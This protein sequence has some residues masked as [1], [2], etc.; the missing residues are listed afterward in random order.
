LARRWP[1]WL[2]ATIFFYGGIL[3]LI[4]IKH[5][6]LPDVNHQPFWWELA[7]WLAFVGY[8]AS[9]TFNIL[10]LFLRFDN[11]GSSVLDPLRDSA[12]GIYLI[13]YVPVLWL[14]YWMFGMS[15]GPV[16]QFTAIIKAVIVFVLTL[17][18]SWAATVALRKIPGATHVL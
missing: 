14:Q 15:F 8:S 7:Y 3:A 10:A 12:Y 4:Y 16:D 18:S 2:G 11:E 6:V 17:A 1:V 9:Q 13:H 5:S